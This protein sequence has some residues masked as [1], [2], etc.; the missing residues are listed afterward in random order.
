[1]RRLLTSLL[2][3]CL[4]FPGI[5]LANDKLVILLD[6][7]NSMWGKVDGQHKISLARDKL[8]A[9]LKD[10]PEQYDIGLMAYGNRRKADCH[11]INTLA[12]PGALPN[13]QLLRQALEIMPKGRSPL[14]TAL[15]QAARLGK[16]ILLVSDG[17]ES[18]DADPCSIS[19][20]LKTDNPDLRIDILAFQTKPAASLE[21][22][23]TNTGG[24]LLAANEASAWEQMASTLK[25]TNPTT[26]NNT[27]VAGG[28]PGLLKLS[29]GASNQPGNLVASFLIYDSDD[30]HIA[31]YTAQT[32]ATHS[33]PPGTYRVD[34]LWGELKQSHT[35]TVTPEQTIS[36]HFDLGPMGQIRLQ[37]QDKTGKPADTNFTFY[38]D[39]EHYF[40]SQLLKHDT[41]QTIP[42]GTYRV[43]AS[44]GGQT[45]ETRLNV[46]AAT[47]TKHVFQ[48]K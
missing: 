5:S 1:M 37:S 20:Q 4:L 8:S 7:S 32:E 2:S 48:F 25:T 35:F 10:T 44:F 46:K 23:A 39:D 15:Q 3:A 36:Y 45:Q 17:N 41:S 9:L 34:M 40:A 27:P 28:K 29:A 33:T 30:H 12:E 22:I 6:A 16:H 19:Q 38:T 21:C 24:T 31:S 14:G 26:N 42:V 18:C 47:V 43:T 13:E 11:D